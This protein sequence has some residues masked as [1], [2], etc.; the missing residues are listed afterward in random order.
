MLPPNAAPSREGGVTSFAS[1][2]ARPSYTD[3][4]NRRHGHASRVGDLIR[5]SEWAEVGR[6][7]AD[8]ALDA[9][10]AQVLDPEESAR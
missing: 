8:A 1:R 7:D 10:T 3:V 5:S 9:E 4:S 6:S 2:F